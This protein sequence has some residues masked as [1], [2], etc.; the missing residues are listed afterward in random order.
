[1]SALIPR[2]FAKKYINRV[3]NEGVFDDWR[4]VLIWSVLAVA[5]ACLSI[6]EEIRYLRIG[7]KGDSE[8]G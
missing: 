6:A 1:M 2:E 8:E 3:A 4:A 5:S 7:Y